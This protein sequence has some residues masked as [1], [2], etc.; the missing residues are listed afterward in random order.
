MELL[1]IYILAIILSL[2]F[3]Q[4]KLVTIFD[5]IIMW[6]MIGWSSG[7]ADYLVYTTR[8]YFPERY[9]TLEPLYA[10]LQN[11]ARNLGSSYSLF[12]IIMSGIALLLKYIS[13]SL[14]TSRRNEVIALWMIFPFIAD[15]NQVREFYAT[16]VAFLGLALFLKLKNTNI[17]IIIAIISCVLA[18]MIHIS[19]FMYLA[20]IIPYLRKKQRKYLFTSGNFNFISLKKIL[21]VIVA[22]YILALFGLLYKIGNLIGLGAKWSQTAEAATI[23]YSSRTFYHFEMIIF[24]IIANI[25]LRRVLAQ[26]SQLSLEENR[27]AY[28]TYI[29]NYLLLLVLAFAFITPDVY[30]VQ[31]EFAIFIYCVASFSYEKKGLV[32]VNTVTAKTSVL[33]LSLL[34]LWLMCGAVPSLR[35]TV[36]IPA[37]Y[38]NL[39]IK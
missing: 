32:T 1:I 16:S 4:S 8:Y 34:F 25:I 19:A 35:E 37:F 2:I 36:L 9:S 5:F 6:I 11:C 7:T 15:I 14:L 3:K 27:I 21:M 31:Q 29:S 17:G 18:G 30:R 33:M 38:D 13:I 22:T 28:W 10:I 39:I 24:F 23:A 20:L 12:L 26:S